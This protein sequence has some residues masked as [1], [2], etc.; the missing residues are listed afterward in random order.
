VQL[1]ETAK[2]AQGNDELVAM[3]STIMLT[4]DKRK[5]R[6]SNS[7]CYMLRKLNYPVVGDRFCKQELSMLPRSCRSV[8]KSKLHL[9]C[10]GIDVTKLFSSF[11]DGDSS[12]LDIHIPIPE[13]LTASHWKNVVNCCK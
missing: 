13:R 9:G 3:I 8:M 1:L 10:F 11:Q 6:L 7:F 2:L 12:I 5:G 4:C